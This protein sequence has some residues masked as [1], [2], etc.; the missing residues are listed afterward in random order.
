MDTLG[1]K[2][3]YYRRIDH[4]DVERRKSRQRRKDGS[5]LDE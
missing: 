3:K 1:V 2:G 4:M 5:A